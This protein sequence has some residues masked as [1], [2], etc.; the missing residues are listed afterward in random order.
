VSWNQWSAQGRQLTFD[1]VK[2][3]STDAAGADTE[4]KLTRTGERARHIC[5][6]QGM[7]PDL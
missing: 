1:N 5:D 3:G 4:Q 2:I 6:L 7:I